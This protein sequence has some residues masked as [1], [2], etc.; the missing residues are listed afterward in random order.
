MKVLIVGAG[1]TG[2]TAALELRRAGITPDI[3]E[4]REGPSGLSR[5]V[6]IMP[7]SI[8]MLRASGVAE[9]ILAEGIAFK[10]VRIYRAKRALLKLDF[11]DLT[12]EQTIIGLAQ[13]RTEALMRETLQDQGVEVRYN[14]EIAA[15]KNEDPEVRVIYASG[16]TKHYDWVIGADGAHSS[17]RETLAI[18]YA[19]DDL[20]GKWSIAD[21]DFGRGYNANTFSVFLLPGGNATVLAPIERHRLRIVSSTPNAV[22]SLPFDLDIRGIRRSATFTISVRQA[23]R[24]LMGRVLLAGDAAHCHSPVGGRGMNLGID[25]AVAAAKAIADGAIEHYHAERH[26][27]GAAVIGFTERIRKTITSTNP[28]ARTMV[29]TVLS[30]AN[31]L[32]FIHP[33][34]LAQIT[35]L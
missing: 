14:T 3:V 6:G 32:P 15:V 23:E 8:E 12:P 34:I 1:P 13:D 2:L 4:K 11:D 25:D 10:H 20:P 7:E 22:E 35:S 28:A 19:G 17:V 9:K 18:P 16:H 21:V 31:A 33:R 5:A 30:T 29:N 27:K 24:Y 26:R